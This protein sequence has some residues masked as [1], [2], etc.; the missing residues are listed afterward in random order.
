MIIL[1]IYFIHTQTHSKDYSISIH[2]LGEE[3]RPSDY[4]HLLYYTYTFIDLSVFISL[5]SVAATRPRAAASWYYLIE[6]ITRHTFT[7]YIHGYEHFLLYLYTKLK[8]HI[9]YKINVQK[10]M[11][12]A[13]VR[14]TH[15]YWHT[16]HNKKNRNDLWPYFPYIFSHREIRIE[17]DTV[18]V[19]L[20][21]SQTFRKP[22]ININFFVC[23]Q[24]EGWSG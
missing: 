22:A 6:F 17:Y 21:Y 7:M 18:L 19:W 11:L 1:S 4:Y 8:I 12:E 14:N 20:L 13:I 23:T 2:I 5:C 24:T 9:I 15:Q 16:K 10:K 3:A